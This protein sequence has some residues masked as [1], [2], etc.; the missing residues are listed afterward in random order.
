MIRVVQQ[1][2]GKAGIWIQV[3][4]PPESKLFLSFFLVALGLRCWMQA[5]S[6]CRRWGLLFTSLHGF[7]IPWLLLL[8]ST[9]SR[10]AAF[11]GC[12]SWTLDPGTQWLWLMGLVSWVHVGSS[13]TR[14]L[15][16]VPCI[17]RRILIH[18]VTW[19]VPGFFLLHNSFLSPYIGAS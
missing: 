14:D 18:C 1:V 8:Q 4:L 13:Q 10:H 6:S 3:S 2:K 9:G 7:L 11:S 12:G 5:F 15:T 19:E 17:G 16:L